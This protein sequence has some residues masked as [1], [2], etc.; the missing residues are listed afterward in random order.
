M[1]VKKLI[2]HFP[3]ESENGFTLVGT[4]LAVFII[5]FL[6]TIVVVAINPVKQLAEARNAQRFADINTLYSSLYQYSID[7]NGTFP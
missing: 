7:N 5:S 2:E 1:R 3:G 4:L 6:S